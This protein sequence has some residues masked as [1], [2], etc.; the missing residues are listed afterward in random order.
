MPA[1]GPQS[2]SSD[3]ALLQSCIKSSIFSAR[4]PPDRR[5][6]C[7]AAPA[8]PVGAPV[9]YVVD[10]VNGSSIV[11]DQAQGMLPSP[12]PYRTCYSASDFAN[13]RNFLFKSKSEACQFTRFEMADGK[14]AAAGGCT[15]SRYS[16]VHVDG[17]GTYRPIGYDFSFSGNAQS[18]KVTVEFRGRDSGRRVGSCP[19]NGSR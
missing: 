17:S 13:P 12:A 18:G 16:T 1:S 15:D 14:L 4:F 5:C 8:G 3:Y 19:A 10:K 2:V 7:A 6:Y 11:A 9:V